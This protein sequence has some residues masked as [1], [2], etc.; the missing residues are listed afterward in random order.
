[1]WADCVAVFFSGRV[2]ELHPTIGQEKQQG[3][4]LYAF[5]IRRSLAAECHAGIELKHRCTSAVVC[6][7]V[8]LL[9]DCE[10]HWS[11]KKADIT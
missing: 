8:Q 5:F 9:H 2:I 7:I 1:M 10:H 3:K 4:R 6:L 11:T